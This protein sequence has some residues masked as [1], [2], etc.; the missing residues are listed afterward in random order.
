MTPYIGPNPA[1]GVSKTLVK[2]AIRKAGGVEHDRLWHTLHTCRQ[3]K[4]FNVRRSD[5]LA[6]SLLQLSRFSLIAVICALT[7]HG[8]FRYHLNKMGLIQETTCIGCGEEEETSSHILCSCPKYENE[9][10]WLLGHEY[11]ERRQIAQVSP[12]KL[13]RFLKACKLEEKVTGLGLE[14]SQNP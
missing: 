7:G 9:R 1:F 8:G 10:L 3:V 4:E 12:D 11:L 2:T 6:K 14:D 13:L 5:K